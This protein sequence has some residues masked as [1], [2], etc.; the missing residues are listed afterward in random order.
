VT[1]RAVAALDK[2]SRWA[3][4]LLHEG[5][6]MVLLKGRS[7]D[8]EIEPAMKVLRKYKCTE[9]EILEGH[10]FAVTSQLNTRESP[11]HCHRRA[12]RIINF[13]VRA[14]MFHVKQADPSSFGSTV[15]Y[16]DLDVPIKIGNVEQLF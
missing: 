7:V 15:L 9:P 13:A 5:G 10:F 6:Q 11:A 2:L 4:P 16:V 12:A 3:L 8:A 14:R 1:A